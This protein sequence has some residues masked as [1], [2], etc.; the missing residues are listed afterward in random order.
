MDQFKDFKTLLPNL[1]VSTIFDVGANRGQSARAFRKACPD[2]RIY[3]FEPVETTY[4]LLVE[5]L[6]GDRNTRCF[7]QALGDKPAALKMDAKPGSLKNRIGDG[8]RGVVVQVSTGDIFCDQHGVRSIDFLKID[9]EGYDLNVCRGFSGMFKSGSVGLVQVEAGLNPE[10]ARH[11]YL[12]A[13]R[14]YLREWGFSLFRI[15]DQAGKPA[16]VRCNAVFISPSLAALN[17]RLPKNRRQTSEW[18]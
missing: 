9:A 13:F 4:Q 8:D 15:Y 1:H 16:A 11:I 18:L 5:S 7:R 3:A 12:E 14:E 17:P 2:A 10:N 6:K